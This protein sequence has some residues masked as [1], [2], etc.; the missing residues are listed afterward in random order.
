VA[1]C[2]G[3]PAGRLSGLGVFHSESFLYGPFVWVHSALNIQ[4]WWFPTRAVPAAR[5]LAQPGPLR[6]QAPVRCRDP[7]PHSGSSSSRLLAPTG[8]TARAQN[9]RLRG[10]GGVRYIAY[11]PRWVRPTAPDATMNLDPAIVEASDPVRAQLLTGQAPGPRRVFPWLQ[12]S[13]R[14][15]RAAACPQRAKR[16]AAAAVLG[17]GDGSHPMGTTE[18]NTGSSNHWFPTSWYCEV[19][20]CME[21]LSRFTFRLL[22]GT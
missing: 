15:L 13:P 3:P 11:C 4:K 18:L 2:P 16:Y 17:M 20:S 12:V 7:R 1:L 9:R 21:D 19:T 5:R 22:P 14:P 6:P 8:A 10:A